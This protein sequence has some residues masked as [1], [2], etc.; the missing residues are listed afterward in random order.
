MAVV[1]A[2]LGTILFAASVRYAGTVDTFSR[3]GASFADLFVPGLRDAGF[4]GGITFP[5]SWT[6]VLV[7]TGLRTDLVDTADFGQNTQLAFAFVVAEFV[8]DRSQQ[9]ALCRKAQVSVQMSYQIAFETNWTF[10]VGR[11]ATL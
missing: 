6:R 11:I 3:G 2:L 5:P 1:V 9:T 4:L 8:A 7:I 10:I